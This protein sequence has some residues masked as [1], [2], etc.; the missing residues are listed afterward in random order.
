MKTLTS[1]E[2]AKNIVQ[3]LIDLGVREFCLAAGSRNS[4]LVAA[5]SASPDLKSYF[6]FEERSAAFFAVGRIQ[7]TQG[8]PVAV[9]CTSGTA[10]AELFPA[11]IEAHYAGLPLLAVTADRP[12]RYRLSGAP[13]AIEQKNLYGVYPEV[14]WEGPVA[15]SQG[16]SWLLSL[17]TSL[18]GAS[19]NRPLHLNVFLDEPLLDAPIE[20]LTYKNLGPVESTLFSKLRSDESLR[21]AEIKALDNKLQKA[22]SDLQNF[23]TRSQ[24]PLVVLG[25]LPAESR[26]AV[27]EFLWRLGAPIFAEGPSGLRQN[28][29]LRPLLVKS[30]ER[31]LGIASFDGVLRLGS[32]PTCRFWRDLDSRILD[33]PVLSLDHRP[34]SGLPRAAHHTVTLGAWLNELQ[35]GSSRARSQNLTSFFE[36]DLLRMESKL[37]LFS[38]Y[39]LAEVSLFHSL[40]KRIPNDSLLFVGNSLPIREWDLAADFTER[41]LEVRANRGANGIDGEVSSFLGLCE[42]GLRSHVAILGDLT[43]LYDLSGPWILPQLGSF[44]MTIFVINNGGGQIFSRLPALQLMNEALRRRAMIQE[45]RVSFE[46]WA[47]LWDLGYEKWTEGIS[48]L[49]TRGNPPSGAEQGIVEIVPD[50]KQTAA[51]WKDFQGLWE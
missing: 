7:A 34:F 13:Q 16:D 40:S 25:G 8:R 27:E 43:S 39:P 41:H 19:L 44:P 36:S 12:E 21:S 23:C 50:A 3:E 28:E 38:K 17:R 49:W 20:T 26:A 4:P 22:R 47:Q 14:F 2:I 31:Q 42:P 6:F 1:F 37:R 35:V 18:W 32:V 51:F 33:I 24:S 11:L 46:G 5:I 48:P 30:G 10:A 45:H 29:K 15:G 9:V